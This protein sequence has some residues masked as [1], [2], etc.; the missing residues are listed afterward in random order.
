M[1]HR[2]SGLSDSVAYTSPP[3][4]RD[5]SM[6]FPAPSIMQR[7][8]SY[9][10]SL[11]DGTVG[12]GA[13]RDSWG[14]GAPFSD[15]HAMN[16]SPSDAG[17]LNSS[18]LASHSVTTESPD[19]SQSDH[20][21]GHAAAAT[22]GVAGL[23]LGTILGR[24]QRS[25]HAATPSNTDLGWNVPPN[26][27]ERG[28]DSTLLSEKPRWWRTG[29]AGGQ[30]EM[31]AAERR[32]GKK[33]KWA[34]CGGILAT[35][36]V[37]GLIA[38]LLGGLLT[39]KKSSSTS[40]STSN[41]PSS[42]NSNPSVTT[43]A[44]SSSS[45]ATSAS[46]PRATTGIAGSTVLFT[47]GSSHTYVN[48]YGGNWAAD[49]ANPWLNEAR[50]NSWTPKLSDP[51]DWTQ[52]IKG[53]NLGGWFVTEPFIVPSLYEKYANGSGGTAVDE[54]TLSQNMGS[55]LASVMEDHYKTFITEQDFMDI[56]A[57][58]L[59]WVRIPFAYWAIETWAGEPY[60]EKVSW[61]YIL[62]ALQ[63]ARKYGLRVN[64]DFHSVPG[65]QNGWNHSGRLGQINWLYGVMG[66]AN[67][68]RSLD[69]VRFLTEFISQ[70]EWTNVIQ[71]FGVINE[72]RGAI[73]GQANIGSFYLETHDMIRGITGYGEGHGPWISVHEAFLGPQAWYGFLQGGGTGPDRMSLDLHQ[74]TCFQDQNQGDLDTL[75]KLPCQWFAGS[76]NQTVNNWG[77]VSNGEFSAAIN[78]CGLW[79]NG[80]GLGSRYDGSFSGYAGKALGTCDYWN[81]PTGWNATTIAGIR[82][83]VL[84]ATDAL[85]SYFWWTWTIGN[86]TQFNHPVNPFWD[87]KLGLEMG[88]VPTDPRVAQGYCVNSV[89]VSPTPT[90]GYGSPYMTGGAGAGTIVAAQRSSYPWPVTTMS[91]GPGSAVFSGSQLNELP[92]YTRTGSPITL[93]TP[94]FSATSGSAASLNGNGWY[95]ATDS[96]SAF[97]PIATCT[98]PD[99]YSAANLAIPT[100]AC[101]AGPLVRRDAQPTPPPGRS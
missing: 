8:S 55:D 33:R 72:P 92:Q 22:T 75:S 24:S 54:Y 27:K 15:R 37:L 82:N 16:R 68:Q 19:F 96:E 85:Q 63:W 50:P 71:M 88:Y 7:D 70:P 61:T 48:P 78:D 5:N 60:L 17:L 12:D 14:S 87:Y 66:V 26:D 101:G 13:A 58:G 43:S 69:Y 52:P 93:P 23:G 94:T 65:S 46:I 99:I 28:V 64:F 49:D 89:G 81:D 97:R 31:D 53:V 86:S 45:S 18:P 95:K 3:L 98:Y 25:R 40:T 21:T 47:D 42:G 73:I 100:S 4:G 67:A 39:R 44:A 83:T 91:Q 1:T 29:G 9:A 57:A 41:P 76:Y 90:T 32:D 2:N 36:L 10:S 6:L 80:V 30:A 56:A 51:W 59:N 77:A 38:G 11:G 62:Q 74:Y 35:L 84:A 34:I 79:V 20:G